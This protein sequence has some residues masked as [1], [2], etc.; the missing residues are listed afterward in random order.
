MNG[1]MNSFDWGFAIAIVLLFAVEF[2]AIIRQDH[3]N[4]LTHKLIRW[5]KE[6]RTVRRRVMVGAF[7]AWLFYHFVIEYW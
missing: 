4:P 7:I 1:A 6:R 5:M 3:D 2:T